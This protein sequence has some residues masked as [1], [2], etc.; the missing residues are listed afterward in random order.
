[1]ASFYARM[2]SPIANEPSRSFEPRQK[3]SGLRIWRSDLHD[4]LEG[5]PRCRLEERRSGL[6]GPAPTRTLQGTLRQTGDGKGEIP[7]HLEEAELPELEGDP[8]Y[9]N[10][11]SS[12]SITTRL[13]GRLSG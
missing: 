13:A 11:D 2:R 12:M 6:H 9:W 10:S 1:V 5:G 7:L 3:V 8:R 4:L